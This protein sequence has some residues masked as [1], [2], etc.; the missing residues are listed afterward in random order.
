M[1]NV[2]SAINGTCGENVGGD[3]DADVDDGD[4]D[5][6]DDDDFGLVIEAANGVITTTKDS[7]VGAQGSCSMPKSSMSAIGRAQSGP[8]SLKNRRYSSPSAS[9]VAVV[10]T[11][12]PSRSVGG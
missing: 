12:G 3:E 7:L 6:D 5:D 2:G 9:S 10:Q 1:G 8:T 11:G 4:D